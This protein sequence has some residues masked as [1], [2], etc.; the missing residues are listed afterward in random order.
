MDLKERLTNDMK[1]AMRMKDE[2]RK[3]TLRMVLAAIKLAEI[4]RRQALD[5]PALLAILQKEVKSRR[6]AIADAERAGR[7]ELAADA[8]AEIAVLE[9]YLPKALTPAEL[10]DLARQAITE[11]GATSPREMG[12]VMKLLM[13]RIQG[14]ADGKQASQIVRKLLG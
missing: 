7:P 5:E 3:R 13:P 8:Q 4:D 14:R 2:L 9:T 10:E 1:N 11:S 6:E 12:K